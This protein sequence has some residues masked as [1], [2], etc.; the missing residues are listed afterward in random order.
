MLVA[1]KKP[2]S[3]GGACAVPFGQEGAEGRDSGS[4][5]DHDDVLFRFGQSELRVVVNIELDAPARDKLRKLVGAE[6]MLLPGIDRI[7]IECYGEMDLAGVC[8]RGRGYR[9]EAGGRRLQY[10][11]NFQKLAAIRHRVYL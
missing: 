11:N 6:P 10:R 5:A 8:F 7:G 9:I 3:A 2:V 1:E 4:R